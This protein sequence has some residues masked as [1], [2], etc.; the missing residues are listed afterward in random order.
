MKYV[1]DRIEEK[2][3]V[4]INEETR[5]VLIRKCE[6]LP[7]VVPGDVVYYDEETKDFIV[8]EGE[9]AERLKNIRAN[10][11]GIWDENE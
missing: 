5:A 1:V 8:D 6:E 9:R 7:K 2:L 11:N 3:V 10:L 4:L